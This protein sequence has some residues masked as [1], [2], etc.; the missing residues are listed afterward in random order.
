V[1]IRV[2]DVLVLL[3]ACCWFPGPGTDIIW[4]G[5]YWCQ[6]IIQHLCFPFC[7]ASLRWPTARPLLLCCFMENK[8]LELLSIALMGFNT[9][10]Q[11]WVPDPQCAQVLG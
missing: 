9:R 2:L 1:N 5:P 8:L 11:F 3:Y 4:L 7:F 6:D 10:L